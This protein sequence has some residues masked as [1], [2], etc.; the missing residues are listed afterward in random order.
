MTYSAL[1]LAVSAP[2]TIS[3]SPK[4]GLVMIIC[5]ILTIAIGK[6]AIKYPDKGAALPAPAMFGGMSFAAL[7]ATAS[8]GHVLGAGVILGLGSI[9]IL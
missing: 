4:V 7:L 8:L 6:Y 5:N 1:L 2:T 9:G 3:W